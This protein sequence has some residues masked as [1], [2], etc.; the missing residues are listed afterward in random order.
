M[1]YLTDTW[2]YI[3][4]TVYSLQ[5]SFIPH[6]ARWYAPPHNFDEVG[7]VAVAVCVT[8]MRWVRC[9]GDGDSVWVMGWV[10]RECRAKVGATSS[11]YQNLVESQ[12][13]PTKVESETGEGITPQL[14]SHNYSI[15]AV[16]SIWKLFR[17]PVSVCLQP[18]R[19]PKKIEFR[20]VLSKFE[21]KTAIIWHLKFCLWMQYRKP[22]LFN[23][24]ADI[25]T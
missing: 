5:F 10:R 1:T 21:S 9:C 4:Y 24:F 12:N 6:L 13:P 17:F 3:Q 25:I 14:N 19:R 22:S 2:L 8:C 15:K 20:A 23:L 7:G 11:L 16:E 18:A